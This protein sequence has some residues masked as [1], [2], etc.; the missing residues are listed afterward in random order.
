MLSLVVATPTK[1]LDRQLEAP[2]I[3][4]KSSSKDQTSVPKSQAAKVEGKNSLP[5]TNTRP[6]AP[7]A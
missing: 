3:P 6:A 7:P 4:F 2:R 1:E 5:A